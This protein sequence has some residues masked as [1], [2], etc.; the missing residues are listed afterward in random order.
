MKIRNPRTGEHDYEIAPLSPEQLVEVAT[1]MRLAQPA[2]ASRDV[3]ERCAILLKLSDAISLHAETIAAALTA[4]TGRAK[5][6]HIEV[7]GTVGLIRRWATGTNAIIASATVQNRPSAIPG[8]ST[9]T[10]LIPYPLVGV[11]SPWNFPMTLALIDAI[12]ALMAGCAVIV[13]P[14]EVTPRFIRPLVAALTEV[15][16]IPLMIIEGDGA[17]GAALVP[18]VDYVAFTGSV[19]TGRKVGAAAAEAFI[20][21]SLELGGKDPMIILASADPAKAAAIALRGSVINNGQACQ[22]IERV[23][24]AREI[25][26]PFLV[27]LAEM[28]A[29]VRLNYPDINSG[30]IGP[31]IFEKQ[32]AI[33]QDQIDDALAKGAR[34]LA[35]GKVENLGGGLYLRPTVLADVTS[36]MAV[37]SQETFGPVIPVTIFDSI[38]QAV[39]LANNGIYGLSGAVIAGTAEEAETISAKLNVG[40]VSIND[41]ALTSMVWDAEKSSFG[42]SG[43]GPSRM[44]DSGLLRFFRKKV[45]IRQSGQARPLTAYSEDAL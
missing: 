16:E 4:D 13:K 40:A 27:M 42:Q 45:L 1:A 29:A 32:A 33:V 25:A 39:T 38:D 26:E 35:G 28:A 5:I 21:A 19:A 24:V 11:I 14:S 43:L 44:G 10:R 9:S 23:Y 7:D 30:D 8:I 31:F 22:S 17:T 15:P 41:G 2:W 6:S 34:L 3:A 18:V 36:E 20:T 37:M 12:P